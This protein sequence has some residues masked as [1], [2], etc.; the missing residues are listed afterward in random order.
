MK[1][2]MPTTLP[3]PKDHSKVRGKAAAAILSQAKYKLKPYSWRVK[4]LNWQKMFVN[5]NNHPRNTVD[6]WVNWLKVLGDEAWVAGGGVVKGIGSPEAA[7]NSTNLP[8]TFTH[9]VGP[10]AHHHQRHPNKHHRRCQSQPNPL[11]MDADLDGKSWNWTWLDDKS[12]LFSPETE[13][14]WILS[15][16]CNRLEHLPVMNDYT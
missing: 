14:E 11:K 13:T 15:R 4:S 16:L 6:E 8:E 9:L 5:N 12:P 7:A 10:R 2:K 1:N 3:R